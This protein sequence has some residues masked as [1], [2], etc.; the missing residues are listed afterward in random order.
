MEQ[1]KIAIDRHRENIGVL[2]LQLKRAVDD[3]IAV[4]T[5]TSTEFE[6]GCLQKAKKCL[7]HTGRLRAIFANGDTDNAFHGSGL[8]YIDSVAGQRPGMSGVPQ[9]N[10]RAWKEV[11]RLRVELR[12]E[13]FRLKRQLKR[14]YQV[15]PGYE[16]MEKGE[17]GENGQILAFLR[18]PNET[19]DP[20]DRW[21]ATI[22]ELQSAYAK[23]PIINLGGPLGHR[24][25]T[26]HEER[27]RD[28]LSI[29]S[30]RVECSEEGSREDSSICPNGD[31][32][33][34]TVTVPADSDSVSRME[35]ECT[36]FIGVALSELSMVQFNDYPYPYTPSIETGSV[37]FGVT[38]LGANQEA[39]VISPLLSPAV[40]R[41]HRVSFDGLALMTHLKT[42]LS[43]DS[44]SDTDTADSCELT[45]LGVQTQCPGTSDCGAFIDSL[46]TYLRDIDAEGTWETGSERTLTDESAALEPEE[47]TDILDRIARGANF[48]ECGSI[49]TI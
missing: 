1:I 19:P 42:H 31:T 13:G 44:G 6:G 49:A 10:L 38:T 25:G 40:C 4:T 45:A 27:A 16:F 8:D 18:P 48:V 39:R 47:L 41:D 35:N 26:Y 22:I 33:A 11:C 14:Y 21:V 43:V 32:R 46:T 7:S 20:D 5:A 3:A 17:K 15:D 12:T 29:M 9:E 37:V 30:T 36:P 24:G 23:L 34:A 2:W 28:L